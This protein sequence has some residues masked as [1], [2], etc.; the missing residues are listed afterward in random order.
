MQAW[1]KDTECMDVGLTGV[2][3]V[4]RSLGNCC[5]IPLSYSPNQCRYYIGNFKFCQKFTACGF[6]REKRSIPAICKKY[7]RFL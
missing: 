4:A 6:A 7:L 1:N 2:E 5:S 3:P